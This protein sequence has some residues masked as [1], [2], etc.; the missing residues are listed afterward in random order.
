MARAVAQAAA[1]GIDLVHLDTIDLAPYADLIGDLPVVLHH[2]NVESLL[3][4]RRIRFVK[5]PITKAY[6]AL[7]TMRIARMETIEC[8]RHALNVVVSQVDA[9]SLHALC[10]EARVAIVPN[11]VDLDYYRPPPDP[12][13]ENRIV[14]AGSMGWFPNRQAVETFCEETWPRI[15]E[16]RPGVAFDVIGH[17]PPPAA[18][19][20]AGVSL[21]GFVED[22]RPI[23][24]RAAAFVVPI[25]I[26]GGTRLKILDAMAMGKAIISTSIGCEGL[27]VTPGTDILVADDPAEFARQTVRVLEDAGLRERLGAA[28][29]RT[30]E[31]TYGWDRVW[32]RLEEAYRAIL[33]DNGRSR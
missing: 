20:A 27:D 14:W 26:A 32:M 8:A 22:T 21:H 30:V 11:G 9:D 24:A 33:A 7:Q 16:A 25:R 19:A 17:S 12:V 6:Y 18:R 2:H 31:R 5:N 29:R 3:L 15:R 10:A 13:D 28:A 23:V 4:G 1:R